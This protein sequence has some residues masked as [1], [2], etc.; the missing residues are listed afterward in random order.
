MAP[1]VQGELRLASVAGVFTL[2]VSLVACSGSSAPSLPACDLNSAAEVLSVTVQNTDQE[3]LQDYPV[4]VFLDA[5]VFDFAVPTQ[6]GSDLAVWDATTHQPTPA[7]LESYDPVAGKGLLWVKLHELASQASLTLLLTAGYATGCSIPRFGGYSVFPFFSDVDD[8][9]WRATN[10]LSVTNTAVE[11]PL[12]ITSRSVI[13]SDGTYNGFPGVA[14]AANGD[15]VLAYKKGPDHVNSPLVVLRRSSHV[16]IQH[17]PDSTRA[18]APTGNV[19]LQIDSTSG[20]VVGVKRR[21]VALQHLRRV[22]AATDAVE[23]VV[24][25]GILGERGG[26][27]EQEAGEHESWQ[28]KRDRSEPGGAVDASFEM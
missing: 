11:G 2:L 22:R 25:V 19:Q 1:A 21:A 14:Q 26:W 9:N 20:V 4:A 15:F 16:E 24:H 8:V 12:T 27:H 3:N 28:R 13:E 18:L 23:E 7:W 10:R 5:T 17:C 6:D